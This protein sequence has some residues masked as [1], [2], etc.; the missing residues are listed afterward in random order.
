MVADRYKR[1]AVM[2]TSDLIRAA[3]MFALALAALSGS[4]GM[5]LAIVGIS[6]VA[7]TPYQPALSA[8]IPSL[9]PE[10]DLPPSLRA[11]LLLL[12]RVQGLLLPAGGANLHGFS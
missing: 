12:E 7:A 6:V 9:V 5:P 8:M 4:V 11:A 3:T 1:R 2:I 10:D